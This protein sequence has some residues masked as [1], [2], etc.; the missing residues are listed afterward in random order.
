MHYQR[1]LIRDTPGN[2]PVSTRKPR[3]STPGS[4][5]STPLFIKFLFSHS[6]GIYLDFF[7]GFPFG[8]FPFGLFPVELFPLTLFASRGRSLRALFFNFPT[9]VECGSRACVRA[10]RRS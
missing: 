2:N 6:P 9:L 5:A 7:E 4:F 1:W 10:W 8:L 3:R